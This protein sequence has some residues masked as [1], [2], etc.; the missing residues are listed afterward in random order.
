L[1]SVQESEVVYQIHNPSSVTNV[2]FNA[3]KTYKSHNHSE[4]SKG[5]ACLN[6]SINTLILEGKARSLLTSKKSSRSDSILDERPEAVTC[7]NGVIFYANEIST[8]TQS[9]YRAIDTTNN[10]YVLFNGDDNGTFN[11]RNTNFTTSEGCDGKSIRDLY[12]EGKAFNFVTSKPT[13]VTGSNSSDNI[14]NWPYAI[15]CSQTADKKVVLFIEILSYSS[16]YTIYYF[17]AFTSSKYLKF[18]A[19]GTFSSNS[20]SDNATAC[21]NM[22]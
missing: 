3:D 19:D 20:S 21:N 11:S 7:G 18:N 6:K 4:A 2:L 12:N 13:D 1:S 15:E 5:S 9:S 14:N 17:Q 16:S 22:S 10:N 8:T